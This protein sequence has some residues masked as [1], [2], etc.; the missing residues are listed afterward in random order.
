MKTPGRGRRRASD[1]GFLSLLFIRRLD[2]QNRREELV[3]DRPQRLEE[4]VS[5][6]ARGAAA[7]LEGEFSLQGN[8]SKGVSNLVLG[9]RHGVTS[10]TSSN[11]SIFSWRRIAR[12]AARSA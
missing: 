3:G 9:V 8:Q 5:I 2:F 1:A 6:H 10:K 12:W 4:V 11:G 7:R